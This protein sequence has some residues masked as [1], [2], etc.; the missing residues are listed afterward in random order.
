MN[1]IWCEKN[2]YGKSMHIIKFVC[3]IFEN[4]GTNNTDKLTIILKYYTTSILILNLFFCR[5]H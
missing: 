1:T 2:A 4:Y 5:R 3:N